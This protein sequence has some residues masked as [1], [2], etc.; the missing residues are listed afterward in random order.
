MRLNI[1]TSIIFF[2]RQAKKAALDQEAAA[3]NWMRWDNERSTRANQDHQRELE[4]SAFRTM[5]KLFRYRQQVNV[6][7]I[8]ISFGNSSSNQTELS[9]IFP[10]FP[11]LRRTSLP[12]AL[13]AAPAS[14]AA[15][16]V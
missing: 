1:Y 16:P 2:L 10:T 3:R 4:C 15:I 13:S 7:N 6:L 14:P 9:R 12:P 5:A 11:L 8:E